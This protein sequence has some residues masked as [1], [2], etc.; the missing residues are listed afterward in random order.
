MLFIQSPVLRYTLFSQFGQ[1]GKVPLKSSR[2]FFDSS[3]KVRKVLESYFRLETPLYFSYSHLVCRSAID[4][5]S[6]GVF[7][8]LLL[9]RVVVKHKDKMSLGVLSDKNMFNV[10]SSVKRNLN[11]SYPYSFNLIF[12]LKNDAAL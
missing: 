10:Y 11:I 12:H 7:R 4:G 5:E 2:L 9:Q 1:E 8:R 6:G 3:E